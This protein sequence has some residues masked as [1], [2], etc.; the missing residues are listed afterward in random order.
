MTIG[1]VGIL[2][3]IGIV[4]ATI[5]PSSSCSRLLENLWIVVLTARWLFR[6][7]ASGSSQD[8]RFSPS[9]LHA[10]LQTSAF[11][12]S[13]RTTGAAM[14]LNKQSDVKNHLSRRP[15][16]NLLPFRPASQ[17]NAN[18]YSEN[19]PGGTK[20]NAPSSGA[21]SGRQPSSVGASITPIAVSISSGD[22]IATSIIRKS[23][24]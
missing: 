4:A 23:Q 6:A 2:N 24:V 21:D 8:L 15:R 3:G 18:G 14:S 12:V 9:A 5:H 17:L 22:T 7:Y 1:A 13:S 11:Q 10:S 20:V 16:K 19:E